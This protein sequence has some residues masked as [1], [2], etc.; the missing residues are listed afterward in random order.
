MWLRAVGRVRIL[1]KGDILNLQNLV[2][3]CKLN[4]Y[5]PGNPTLAWHPA[6]LIK[7]WGCVDLSMDTMHLKDPLVLFG[8]EGSALSLPLFV[9][10]HALPLFFNNGKEPLRKKTLYGTK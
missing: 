2:C 3:L 8:Y 7:K 1:L 4:N 10:S 6:C 9:L 5:V